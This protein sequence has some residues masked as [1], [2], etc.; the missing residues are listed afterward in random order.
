[1]NVSIVEEAFYQSTRFPRK[2]VL[3]GEISWQHDLV[4]FLFLL[5]I[6]WRALCSSSY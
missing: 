1:M 4:G 3:L 2:C 5:L 6:T